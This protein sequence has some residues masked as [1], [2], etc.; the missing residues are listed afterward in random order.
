[1][2][3]KLKTVNWLSYRDA[4]GDPADIEGLL[5]EISSNSDQADEALSEL[6]DRLI[7]PGVVCSVGPNAI[8]VLLELLPTVEPEVEDRLYMILS[9]FD[10]HIRF[11]DDEMISRCSPIEPF[12]SYEDLRRAVRDSLNKG[13][14]LYQAVIENP[15]PAQL[16]KLRAAASLLGEAAH[17]EPDLLPLYEDLI[18]SAQEPQMLVDVFM[19]A[20]T[21]GQ[22]SEAWRHM[23]R[24][25]IE[26]G[27][28]RRVVSGLAAVFLI[29]ESGP[30]IS[31]EADDVFLSC[32]GT[33]GWYTVQDVARRL[34]RTTLR[35]LYSLLLVPG[36]GSMAFVELHQAFHF[37]SVCFD[38][39]LRLRGE[40]SASGTKHGWFFE[41][42]GTAAPPPEKLSPDQSLL[43]A[44]L[45]DA[46]VLWSQ[47][48]NLWS[49]FGLPGD[50][51]E[52]RALAESNGDI[53]TA[54]P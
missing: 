32:R 1:M 33:M 54:S 40:S 11:G 25:L 4:S 49:I 23:L 41:V 38:R 26:A 24:R 12:A 28:T 6:E 42:E 35:R 43:L 36:P 7:I 53:P 31:T 13:K 37:L 27:R 50:R 16:D 21:I 3:S 9:F 5:A 29:E 17:G 51:W 10:R 44:R 52:L 47:N 8:E 19:A 34:S 45:A 15:E 18:V 39:H 48:T 2:T 22:D 20:R 14:E 30:A 46:D